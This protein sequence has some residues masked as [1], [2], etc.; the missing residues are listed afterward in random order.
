MIA[1]ITGGTGF[2]GSLLAEQLVQDGWQVYWL[3]TKN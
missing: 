2:I 3:G 1:F